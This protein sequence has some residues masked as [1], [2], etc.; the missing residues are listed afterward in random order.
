MNPFRSF[1]LLYSSSTRNLSAQGS[2]LNCKSTS[3][4]TKSATAT[5]GVHR[6]RSLDVVAKGVVHLLCNSS[7]EGGLCHVYLVGTRHMSQESCKK[8]KAVMK[9]IKPQALFLELCESSAGE[10]MFPQ[11]VQVATMHQM[12]DMWKGHY[13]LPADICSIWSSEKDLPQQGAAPKSEFRIAYEE[14]ISHG[15]TVYLGD[16][17]IHVKRIVTWSISAELKKRPDLSASALEEHKKAFP[18]IWE[19]IL[20]ERDMFVFLL[21]LTLS[22]PF[23]LK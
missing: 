4:K 8:V 20:T 16:R 15:A 9:Y 10:E 11:K 18:F 14:A 6:A 21:N 3:R 1:R 2:Q 7:A 12:V 19:T 13:I 23:S 17:P 22:Y 5:G